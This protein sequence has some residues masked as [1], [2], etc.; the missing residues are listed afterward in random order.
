MDIKRLHLA[1]WRSP[2][3]HCHYHGVT[4]N[5]GVTFGHFWI[6][7]FFWKIVKNL[8]YLAVG[9]RLTTS[10]SLKN[11][12]ESTSLRDLP[13]FHH[14]ASSWVEAFLHVKLW[15]KWQS[16]QEEAAQ[17]FPPAASQTFP[18]NEV[19]ELRVSGNYNKRVDQQGRTILS[20]VINDSRY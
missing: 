19:R 9:M 13:H 2:T 6:F 7:R 15:R 20:I 8:F 12:I 11:K 5:F 16:T 1:R 18:K 4:Q 14:T 3:H 10:R 17:G